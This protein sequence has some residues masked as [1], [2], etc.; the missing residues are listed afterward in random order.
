MQNLV[1]GCALFSDPR[2][3]ILDLITRP[4][5]SLTTRPILAWQTIIQDVSIATRSTLNKSNTNGSAGR[6]S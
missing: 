1:R 2:K 4:A 5:N 6:P 3:T